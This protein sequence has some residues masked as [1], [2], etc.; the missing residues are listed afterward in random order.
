MELH[1]AR[2]E[3]DCES[4]C[5][6]SDHEKKEHG[7]TC[8]DFIYFIFFLPTAKDGAKDEQESLSLNVDVRNKWNGLLFT[9]NY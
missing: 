3:V 9:R 6:E 4:I 2:V 8:F 7:D 1:K 5:A